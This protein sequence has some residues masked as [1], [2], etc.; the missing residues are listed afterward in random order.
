MNQ[1]SKKCLYSLI[2]YFVSFLFNAQGFAGE[3]GYQYK[4][5]NLLK[6]GLSYRMSDS[7]NENPLNVN[8]ILNTNFKD[9]NLLLV[10]IQK[11]FL[12]IFEGGLNLST[13][14][15]EPVVG[16]NFFNGIR[17]NIGYSFPY[18][19]NMTNNNRFTFG[20]Y[21]AIGSKDYY[22]QFKTMW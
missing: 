20:L 6:I 2:I 12:Y 3:I 22:D 16:L 9:S 18:Q 8:C 13:S 11:R 10:G 4:Y 5:S 15:V 1:I 19:P 21:L 14:D 17:F 7:K